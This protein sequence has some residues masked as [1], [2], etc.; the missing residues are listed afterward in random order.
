M[1]VC[2]SNI[3]FYDNENKGVDQCGARFL[4]NADWLKLAAMKF[5]MCVC[6]FS[7]CF[8]IFNSDWLKNKRQRSLY[9]YG[10]I[11]KNLCCMVLQKFLVQ[12]RSGQVK[13]AQAVHSVVD[14]LDIK[15][16]Y[17]DAI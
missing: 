9:F 16:F 11:P 1:C 15:R 3:G 12:V 8:L 14:G 17:T 10:S 5:S 13:P 6:V 4:L 7:C 2:C